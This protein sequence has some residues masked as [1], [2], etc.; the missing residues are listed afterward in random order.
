[1]RRRDAGGGKGSAI[2]N[3]PRVFGLGKRRALLVK[4]PLEQRQD[5]ESR[6]PPR[7]LGASEPRSLG[8]S[9]RRSVGASERR[10]V[11]ASERRSVGASNCGGRFAGKSEAKFAVGGGLGLIESRAKNQANGL[12][13]ASPG[14]ASRKA[15]SL[16]KGHERRPGWMVRKMKSPNG[17]RPSPAVVPPRW[18]WVRFS[19][20]TQGGARGSLALGS[21]AA[22]PLALCGAR[23]TQVHGR[24]KSPAPG[25]RRSSAPSAAAPAA[26]IGATSPLHEPLSRR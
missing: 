9:E 24:L 1:M 2:K 23:H 13:Q 14:Q 18:G 17:A 12:K 7:S 4:T 6:P 5:L 19:R 10:S 25:I 3:F 16:S 20:F 15:L 11:G 26:R 21:L 8:A 22:G